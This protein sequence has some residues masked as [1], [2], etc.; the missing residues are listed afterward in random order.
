MRIVKLRFHTGEEFYF[1]CV[2]AIY[3]LFSARE[4]GI[5]YNSLG[6]AGLPYGNKRCSVTRHEMH[7]TAQFNN[8]A[9]IQ[10]ADSRVPR[11]IRTAKSYSAFYLVRF[12]DGRELY[13]GSLRVLCRMLSEEE[14]GISHA[15]L[16]SK[17]RR[18]KL[19]YGNKRCMIHQ[20][21]LLRHPHSQKHD[22]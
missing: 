10:T 18:G 16:L 14:L 19:P 20:I 3:D 8:F 11:H 22:E 21:F 5:E 17:C 13:F 6:G 9:D 15:A 1:G 12:T 7:G 4:L 2:R